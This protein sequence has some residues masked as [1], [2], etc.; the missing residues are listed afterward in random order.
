MINQRYK[1]IKKIG[2][3]RSEVFLCEDVENS[4]IPF[5]IKILKPD[6]GKEEKISFRNEFFILKKLEHPNI[7]RAEEF[8]NV[9]IS[10]NEYVTEGSLYITS[11]YFPSFELSNSKLNIDEKLIREIT[12]QICC[13]LYYLH[14]SNYIYYDLKLENILINSDVT[15]PKLKLIDLGLSHYSPPEIIEIVQGTANYIA[16][17]LLKKEPH[18]FRVDLYSLGILLYR[19]VYDK[20]PFDYENELDIYKAHI[21]EEFKFPE[22]ERFSNEFLRLIKY[23]LKKNPDERPKDTLAILELLGFEIDES[24]RKDFIPVKI[25]SGRQDAINILDTYINDKSSSEIVVVKGFDNS[26]KT[27]LLNQTYALHE[28]SILFNNLKGKSG[29]ELVKVLIKNLLYSENIFKQLEQ[30]DIKDIHETINIADSISSE[31]IFRIVSLLTKN[32]TAV[33]LFDDYNLLDDYTIEIFNSIMPVFQINGIKII[34]TETSETDYRSGELNN[35]REFSLGSFTDVQLRDFINEAFHLSFPK[36]ELNNLILNYSD[37]LP[38]NVISFIK[39]IILL[40][41]M[42]FNSDGVIISDK[43]EDLE[44]LENSYDVIYDKRLNGLGKS[45][46]FTIKLISCFDITPDYKTIQKILNANSKDFD[47]I[48]SN[49]QTNN[50]LV[51]YSLNNT[52]QIGSDGLK[53]HVYDLLNNKIKWHSQIATKLSELFPDFNPTELARQFELAEQLEESYKVY[54][55]QIEQAEKNSAYSFI[56]KIIIH[57]LELPFELKIITSLQIKLAEINYK[58]SDFKKAI[59]IIKKIDLENLSEEIRIDINFIFASSLV[60]SGEYQ[61]GRNFLNSLI[62][63]VKAPG[64]K[65]KFLSELAYAEFELGKYA[66]AVEKASEIVSSSSNDNELNGKCYNLLGMNEIYNTSNLE[67]ALKWFNKAKGNYEIAKLPRRLAGMEVNIGNIYNILGNYDEAKNH[68]ENASKL[69]QSIG[70]LDQEGVLQLNMGIF[71]FERRQL[72][73]SIEMYSLALKIFLSIGNF[74]N[75]GLAFLNLGE[76]H[77]YLCEY[78]KAYDSLNEALN[79]FQKKNL[80]EDEMEALFLLGKLF[81]KIGLKKEFSKVTESSEKLIKENSLSGKHLINQKLLTFYRQYLVNESNDMNQLDEIYL[82]YKKLEDRTNYIE[83]IF[84]KTNLCI[85]QNDFQQALTVLESAE[86]IEYCKQ[87]DIFEAERQYFLGILSGMVSSDKLSPPLEY[88][89]YAYGL[90]NDKSISEITWKILFSLAVYYGQRGNY[91]KS[92]TYAS[93]TRELIQ[94]VMEQIETPRLRKSFTERKDIHLIVSTLEKLE[95]N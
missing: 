4:R 30:N 39:D 46:L 7:I 90:I 87:N 56:R 66:E 82:E 63:N 50:L 92:K 74:Q 38:G 73:Q 76:A 67:N 88:F 78:Q 42:K 45:E 85:N 59:E 20:F 33:L 18:D 68:W 17:E 55:K 54:H 35:I 2:E 27:S 6:A 83:T 57:L 62:E 43:P 14:Q 40:E 13:A 8:G 5:A 53:K 29:V 44:I 65:R 9:L 61:E 69:N 48:I 93:Y 72:E 95:T 28:E 71:Y 25:F 91:Q 86:L 16:P 22:T 19:I 52:L 37:L 58:L 70:N 84:L 94:Y 75:Q 79:I 47:Q 77:F 31:Q 41:I 26:G 32:S 80:P 89:E 10:E 60:G 11:E 34:L 51:R 21:E 3:G 1:I 12:R 23:L 24:I 64:K 15:K 81:Y 49:L 36:N